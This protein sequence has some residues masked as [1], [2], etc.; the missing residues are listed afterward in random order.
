MKTFDTVEE[1]LSHIQETRK[2]A[3][4]SVKDSEHKP[5]EFRHGAY[6]VNWTAYESYGFFIFGEVV[7]PQAPE[8]DDPDAQAEHEYEVEY[9]QESRAN[10][11]IFGRCYS[12]ACSGGELGTTHVTRMAP[13]S[14]EIFD[15]AQAN[16]WRHLAPSN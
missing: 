7:E 10:G 4:E 5:D 13:I 8:G 2:Q 1:M 15:R 12:V 14:K 11:Y 3:R 16:G 6:F 9:D